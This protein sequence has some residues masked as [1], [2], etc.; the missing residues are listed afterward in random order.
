M[1]NGN[2]MQSARKPTKA[3]TICDR[4]ENHKVLASTNKTNR[5]HMRTGN[6]HRCHNLRIAIRTK[7]QP[8]ASRK[9]TK[10]IERTQRKVVRS[11]HPTE[12]K[13]HSAIVGYEYMWISC[14]PIVNINVHRLD[15]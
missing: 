7:S 3:T 5:E 6:P 13:Q 14:F 11:Y 12:M 8:S 1:R 2:S 4:R 15:L 10:T 9:T